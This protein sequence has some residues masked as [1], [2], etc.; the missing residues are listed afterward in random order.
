M[1]YNLHFTP[2][3]LLIR[4]PSRLKN[5]L[6]SLVGG[7]TTAA[8]D[9]LQVLSWSHLWE[10]KR[11]DGGEKDAGREGEMRGAEKAWII[12]V[13]WANGKWLF[14]GDCLMSDSGLYQWIIYSRS[15][16][17]ISLMKQRLVVGAVQPPEGTRLKVAGQ[18]KS[19]GS[20]RWRDVKNITL[21]HGNEIFGNT[22]GN[23]WFHKKKDLLKI[24]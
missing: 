6:I 8:S 23:T 12:N 15:G 19:G 14:H 4:G 13:L 9:L 17:N 1:F 16:V 21:K 2:R 24:I 20:K 7:Q 18:S 5:L 10:K 11:W 3:F 22:V